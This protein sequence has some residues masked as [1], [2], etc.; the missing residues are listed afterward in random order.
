MRDF[1]VQITFRGIS[2]TH[3]LEAAIRGHATQLGEHAHRPTSCQVVVESPHR[4]QHKGR[5]YRVR[6]STHVPVGGDIVSQHA[7]TDLHAV[8]R[9]AF[10]AARRQL[11][12]A[13]RRRRDLRR[14]LTDF[15]IASA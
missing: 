8:L 12:D 6:V 10:D 2:P 3:A 14:S 9:D 13:E 4:R 5:V 1:P 11:E 7:G 15:P